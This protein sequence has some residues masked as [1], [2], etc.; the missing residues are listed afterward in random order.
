VRAKPLAAGYFCKI[1]GHPDFIV[2]GK[3]TRK[4]KVL[5]PD[6]TY[7]TR[8]VPAKH[9]PVEVWEDDN[10]QNDD[11]EAKGRT[12]ENGEYEIRFCADG[13]GVF[14]PNQI[15][16]YVKVLAREPNPGLNIYDAVQRIPPIGTAGDFSRHY[17][18][19]KLSSEKGSF[20]RREGPH[21]VTFNFDFSN[22]DTWS[23]VLNIFENLYYARQYWYEKVS[24]TEIAAVS[25]KAVWGPS[26]YE[27]TKLGRAVWSDFTD[28]D[29]ITGQILQVDKNDPWNDSEIIAAWGH[30]IQRWAGGEGNGTCY[31]DDNPPSQ[32]DMVTY[33]AH[34]DDKRVPASDKVDAWG[35]GWAIYYQSAVRR[36]MGQSNYTTFSDVFVYDV[37]ANGFQHGTDDNEYTVASALWDLDDSAQDGEDRV[38]HGEEA[39]LGVFL[40]DKFANKSPCT[41]GNFLRA[42]E[43]DGRPHD[44]AV[45]AAVDQNVDGASSNFETQQMMTRPTLDTGAFAAP[46][47]APPAASDT[48][49]W[50]WWRQMLFLVDN[51]PSMS[52]KISSLQPVI[53]DQVDRIYGNPS[54]TEFN[55]Y[56]FNASTTEPQ[57]H[58]QGSFY[59]DL[60]KPQVDTLSTAGTDNGCTVDAMNAVAKGLQ[61]VPNSD[62]WLYT[63]GDATGTASGVESVKQLL[64]DYGTQASFVLLGGCSST[65]QALDAD[66]QRRLHNVAQADLGLAAADE[67]PDG[68]LPYLLTSAAS[69]GQFLFVSEADLE[70]ASEI[71][72]AQLT[73]SAGAGRWSDYVSEEP[74]YRYDELA[75]WE[76]NWI[77][78]RTGPTQTLPAD[79]DYT[80]VL[81]PG[82]FEYYDTSWAQVRLFQNGYISMQS[83]ATADP[84]NGAIPDDDDPNGAIY[85][86]WDD[87][88]YDTAGDANLT[89]Y[90]EIWTESSGDWFA[91]EY[92]DFAID[93]IW[94]YPDPDVTFQFQLNT[95]TG[96]IRLL[97]AEVPNSSEHG[98]D[99]AAS[100]TIGI[101]SPER[102]GE[103]VTGVQVSHD[104]ATGASD[105]MGYEFT[106]VPPQPSKTYSIT[107]D[108]TMESV[109]FL[110]TGF[111]GS[112]DL[113]QIEDSNGD[114]VY[115]DELGDVICYTL[116]RV[117]YVQA[118][119]NGRTGTWTA[120]VTPGNT[121]QATYAFT[122]LGDSAITPQSGP[123]RSR[124]TS[125]G[126]RVQVDLGRTID[127]DQLTGWFNSPNGGAFGPPSFDL[128]DD[129]NHADGQAGDGV[130]GSDPLT[131]FKSGTAYLR[132]TGTVNGET[133]ERSV[134]GAYTF[135]PVSL[136]SLGDGVHTGDAETELQ[137]RLRNDDSVEHCYYFDIREPDGWTYDFWDSL[138]PCLPAG[139]T[140]TH[141]VHITPTRTLPS[142]ATGLVAVTAIETEKGVM[143]SSD[144]A[145]ITRRRPADNVFL[146]PLADEVAPGGETTKVRA[147]V[148][149]TDGVPVADGIPVQ[150]STNLGN[151]SP[152]SATTEDGRAEFTFTSG[153]STGT[154]TL[155][156]QT[157]NGASGSADIVVQPPAVTSVRISAG[158]T[159]LP[160]D[161][162]ATTTVTAKVSNR[163]GDPVQG[164]TVR[165]A[166]SGDDGDRGRV[167]GT[168]V[169][170]GTT[171]S[172]GELAAT[173]TA[174]TEGGGA[175]ITTDLLAP[176]G[177]GGYELVQTN[178]V[179]I[180]L[181]APIYLPIV[182]R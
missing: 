151:V 32:S 52:G 64:A 23:A 20:D 71:L 125:G 3:I 106:R 56:T 111:S 11:F 66:Q 80:S 58:I 164:E 34:A 18:Y 153:A 12:D 94:S 30:F 133:I 119:V 165:I 47:L 129:G 83:N 37:E 107:V 177:T 10:K 50:I 105:N 9:V 90:S 130:F 127:D 126:E 42:W 96:D 45:A 74:T 120:T 27:D 87:L 68:I 182:M 17:N 121:G 70:D 114:P 61:Q 104:D 167:N 8:T 147:V 67:I 44:N 110:L 109:S 41:F 171:N 159:A 35:K 122:T 2:K 131:V 69:G 1:P 154:A 176:D 57:P 150:F 178:R 21:T 86:L 180:T 63:D 99:G 162:A 140:Y 15:E 143:R 40:N 116:D 161:G 59:P 117:Q 88:E 81:V 112:L 75:S 91:I 170:T 72:R 51:S 92:Y 89:T 7:T 16:L 6:G 175:T 55:L 132:V 134:P 102:I 166:V 98:F 14:K 158:T 84:Y 100:A 113:L 139:D 138:G 24:D 5:Q 78:T 155:T 149:G 172:V 53:K 108:S 148:V 79:N 103:P 144:S 38:S 60:I 101:E 13:D 95:E 49:P 46:Q 85:A 31:D 43:E 48:N 157:P 145:R 73:H 25:V 152:S 22:N 141:T 4:D 82:G 77:D 76:Y 65:M 136:T 179:I 181:A 115:C 173:Y 118:P 26:E 33:R 93:Q 174:G 169:M 128:Y 36:W 146:E 19:V 28:D 39:L 163:A 137:F 124:S 160:A 156:A 54:G 29:I 135:Q 142:G 62:V 123:D 168:G 97:Y